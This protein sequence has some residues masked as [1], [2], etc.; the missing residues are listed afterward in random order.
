MDIFANYPHIDSLFVRLARYKA[1]IEETSTRFRTGRT[2]LLHTPPTAPVSINWPKARKLVP[3]LPT[4]WRAPT[5]PRFGKSH[6]GSGRSPFPFTVKAC[7]HKDGIE[8]LYNMLTL[9]AAE[10]EEFDARYCATV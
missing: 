2:P 9:L 7:S 8:A 6:T 4:G 1:H 10:L 3:L 5:A